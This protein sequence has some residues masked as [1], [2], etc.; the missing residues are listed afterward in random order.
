MNGLWLILMAAGLMLVSGLPACGCSRQSNAAQRSATALMLLGSAI[1][2]CG[3]IV[4][5]LSSAPCMLSFPWH[6]P[7]GRFS[8]AL[9]PLSAVF[10]IPVFTIPTLGS[11]YGLDYWKQSEH[12]DNGRGLS[13]FYGLLAGAMVMVV[14][15]RD[16]VLLL[17]FWEIMA[18][19]AFFLAT[20]ENE[21]SEVRRAGW[22]YLVATHA[23]TVCLLALFA[24]LRHLSGSFA[25]ETIDPGLLTRD[26]ATALFILTVIGFGF[27]AGIMPLHIWLPGAHA[28]AP[29]HVSAVMSG[30]MLKMGIYGIIRIL[31]LLPVTE[32]WN[33]GVL[34]GLGALTGILGMAF[35]LGQND[36]KRLLAYSSIE[37]IGIIAMGIGLALLGRT[38][39]RAD[40]IL[41]GLGGALLHAWNHSLFKSL[42]FMNA[43][44]I[45]HAVHSRNM[46]RMGGLAKFMPQTAGL[47]LLGAVAICGLPPLNGFISE[48]LIYIGLF[49]TLE[50][51]PAAA[52]GVVA[53]ALIGALALAC[54]VKIYSAV[55]LGQPRCAFQTM[56]HDPKPLMRYPMIV[57][58]LG[59]IALGI[60]P[61]LGLPLLQKA[62]AQW[63]DPAVAENLLLHSLAPLQWISITALALILIAAL[64]IVLLRLK[65]RRAAAPIGTWS[66]GYAQ[67][68]PRAQYTGSSLAEMLTGLFAWALHPR[69]QRP[70]IDS[71][72]P[73]GTRFAAE[74]PDT[75]LERAILPVFHYSARQMMKLRLLQ[76]GRVQIYLLYILIVLLFLLF[77]ESLG[78]GR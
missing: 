74:F 5:L 55:F 53:L 25:L 50:T 70:A 60:F 23:G 38:F 49:Q 13:L 45:M 2:W 1:G 18:L 39:H 69:T 42:L 67:P 21:K 36:I 64:S 63:M 62:A 34:L 51:C 4:A 56:P 8:V 10:L 33:G 43:G 59:C 31:T 9:D 47:F 78:I 30:V 17:I 73:S 35:A 27:K 15:A 22:V 44:T 76:Q 40:L 19:A 11:I 7:W 16:S 20:T 46:N 52:T 54:F 66:C 72:F 28:N 14:I 68:V 77:W 75:L 24:L 29:S 65:I 71:V 3:L 32:A 61:Q 41:L 6:L 48:W 58:A 26:A 12:P 37:N 57:P